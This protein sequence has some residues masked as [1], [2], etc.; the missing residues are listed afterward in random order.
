MYSADI[1]WRPESVTKR[2]TRYVQCRYFMETENRDKE[3]NSICTVQIFYRDR[4]A[5]QRDELDMYSADILQRPET[6]VCAQHSFEFTIINFSKMF[7][8]L[9]QTHRPTEFENREKQVQLSCNRPC[10]PIGLWGLCIL[11]LS[12]QSAHRWRWRQ[13]YAT[14]ALYFCQEY[15]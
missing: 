13:P 15:S 8:T 4:K 5:W 3:I 12:S 9:R 10:K 6:F 14:A 11:T 2:W 1:L 7:K